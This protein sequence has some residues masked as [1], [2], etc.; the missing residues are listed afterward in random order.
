VTGATPD[1]RPGEP[2]LD[3]TVSERIRSA[4]ARLSHET[5]SLLSRAVRIPSVT[6]TYPGQ[7][8]AAAVGGESRVAELLAETY[9]AAG[10][11]AELFGSV[12]GRDNAVARL[13]GSGGGRSLLFN[14]HLDVVPPGPEAEWTGGDP[15]SGRVAGGRVWGRGACD[16]KGGLVAQAM[17]GRA[18]RE[19]GVR[20]RGDLVF[21]AVVGE[22]MME[23]RLGT[24]AC[25]E[26]GYRADAAVVAEPSSPPTRLAVCPVS[27]GVLW[28]TLT[29]EGKATHPALRGETVRPGGLGEAVGVSAVDKI[30][31]L[32][33]ALGRLEAEWRT[34]KTHP[35]FAPG[36]FSIM[37][38]VVVA[39]PRSGLVP[40]FVPD[41][42]RMEV[43]VWHHPDDE[44]EDVRR[45]V[46]TELGRAAD[47][48]AWL[49]VH[50][51]RVEWR[52]HWPK[53]VLD[54]GHPIV[55]AT[56]RAHGRSCGS[57]AAVQGFP[58]VEDMTWLNAAGIPAINYG[59]GDLRAAHAVDEHLDV[60]E[61]LTATLTFAL[62]AA[63]WC[64]VSRD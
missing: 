39:G 4:A 15:W 50:R 60:G 34:T 58:A 31:L 17:A 33:A 38:G 63:E 30:F 27:P 11:E 61:L 43:L 2:A 35:L 1:P 21:Q 32:H 9:R 18:L 59:P 44:A 26:R 10:A 3:E 53:S 64:G 62:L 37:P 20:L 24:T 51:P 7:D 16:M 57:R 29:V 6:P 45:E 40:F 56:A 19:A 41:E 49:R 54:A 55:A 28:F 8:F 42:A 22:E 47:A 14:G 46:E 13:R 25:V 52:H 12:R 23:H 48:D 36:H 5:V